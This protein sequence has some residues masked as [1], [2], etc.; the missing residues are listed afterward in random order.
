MQSCQLYTILIDLKMK[1]RLKKKEKT[2]KSLTN[3]KKVKS[4]SYKVLEVAYKERV[5]VLRVP[6]SLKFT[7]IDAVSNLYEL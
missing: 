3:T 7:V 6:V 4:L 5:R 2:R 1:M